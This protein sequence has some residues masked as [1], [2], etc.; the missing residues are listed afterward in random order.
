M[1]PETLRELM[2]S[3]PGGTLLQLFLVGLGLLIAG[4][5]TG[6]GNRLGEKTVDRFD[7]PDEPVAP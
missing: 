1:I 6:V 7:Q 5:L 2:A 4:Y 3:I